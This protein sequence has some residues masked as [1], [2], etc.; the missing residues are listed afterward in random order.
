MTNLKLT[1]LSLLVLLAIPSCVGKNKQEQVK[2]R[3]EHKMEVVH[4]TK[5]D[6]LKLV[7][8]FEKNPKE[9]KYEGDKPAIVDFYATW[10]G[11]CKVLSPII[12]EL[13]KEYDGKL[14]VYKVDVD[15][16]EDLAA[17]FNVRSIPTLLW[18]PMKGEPFLSQGMMPKA[19]LKKSIDDKL[20]K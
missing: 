20:L 10:C 7:Y 6:F 11:P 9:W 2:E 3:K 19:E 14:V 13:A 5:A 16:E 15:K 1:L 12:E 18:I 17:A 8:D 4:L